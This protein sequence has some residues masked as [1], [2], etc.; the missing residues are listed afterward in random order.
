MLPIGTSTERC[1]VAFAE[2]PYIKH[3]CPLLHHL[4]T[5]RQVR[6]MVIGT[7]YR[8]GLGVGELPLD[9][10]GGIAHLVEPGTSR[11]SGGVGAVF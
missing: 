1:D 4:R 3:V 6:R 10:V 5:I 2:N 7:P 9:P 8:I 11:G